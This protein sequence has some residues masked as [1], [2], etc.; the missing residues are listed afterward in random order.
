MSKTYNKAVIVM[1]PVDFNNS[2]EVAKNFMGKEF[3]TL[4]EV[5]TAVTDALEEDEDVEN[6]EVLVYKIDEFCKAC[7]DQQFDSLTEYF[8]TTVYLIPIEV[9][10]ESLASIIL[11]ND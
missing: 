1:I 7:N 5:A 11:N 9:E 4:G 6:S 2:I 10:E 8:L 3:K